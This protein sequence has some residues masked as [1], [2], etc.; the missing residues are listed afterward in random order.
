MSELSVYIKIKKREIFSN[1]LM[2]EYG[3]CFIYVKF[4]LQIMRSIYVNVKNH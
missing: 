2:V 4:L 1:K 3:T